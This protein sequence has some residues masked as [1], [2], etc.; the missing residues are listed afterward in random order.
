MEIQR[1]LFTKGT[2]EMKIYNKTPKGWTDP[3]D[4]TRTCTAHFYRPITYID[5]FP[6]LTLTM[7]KLDRGKIIFT[8]DNWYYADYYTRKVPKK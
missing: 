3:K 1:L 5:V 4:I 8:G 2:E 6:E 7:F